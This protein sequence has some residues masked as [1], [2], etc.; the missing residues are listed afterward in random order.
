MAKLSTEINQETMLKL[1]R[2]AKRVGMTPEEAA[3]VIVTK[4]VQF[5][6]GLLVAPT[7]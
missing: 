1:T 3:R 4:G 7:K 6:L 5:F 2:R